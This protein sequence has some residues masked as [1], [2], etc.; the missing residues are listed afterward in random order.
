MSQLFLFLASKVATVRARF[1]REE[2]ASAV[3]YG[4]L[5][6]LIAAFVVGTV[7][8]LGPKIKD[9]WPSGGSSCPRPSPGRRARPRG[10]DDRGHRFAA[11]P[12]VGLAI[13][14]VLWAIASRPRKVKIPQ[15]MGFGDQ[16]D[17]HRF[18]AV[19]RLA[20]QALKGKAYGTRLADDLPRAG[21][22]YSPSEFLTAITIGAA[23][24]SLPFGA[25]TKNLFVAIAVALA[26]FIGARA[27]VRFRSERWRRRFDEELPEALDLLAGSLEAGS[28]LPQAM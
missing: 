25:L 28:S 15:G 13:A 17:A 22:G 12:F 11:A 8:P 27:F 24:L 2:G 16:E 1:S 3:E 7:A 14:L 4:M 19:G 20:E 18:G 21:I 10:G 26:T 23:T 6:A 9:A 5:V